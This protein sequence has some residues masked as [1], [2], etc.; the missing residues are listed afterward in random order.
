MLCNYLGRAGHEVF[1][2]ALDASARIV[3]PQSATLAARLDEPSP[4]TGGPLGFAPL[5]ALLYGSCALQSTL[6]PHRLPGHHFHRHGIHRLCSS[7]SRRN[8]AYC[9]AGQKFAYSLAFRNLI[10]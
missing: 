1:L 2:I 8:P 9:P 10:V 3:A 6:G 7:R 5:T 4:R